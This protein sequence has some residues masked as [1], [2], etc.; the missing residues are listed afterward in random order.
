MILYHGSNVQ[1]PEPRLLK[2]QRDLDFG[3][4]FYASFPE[5][6]SYAKQ[7]ALKNAKDS[8]GNIDVKKN[9]VIIKFEID[10]N[11][12]RNVLEFKERNA[13]FIDFVFHTRLNYLKENLPYDVIIGYMADGTVDN[14]MMFY[15]KHKSKLAEKFVKWCYKLPFNLHRQIVIKSQSLCDEI[16]IKKVENLK[17][18]VIYESK[19]N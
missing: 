17:G 6:I 8:L 10:E 5:D 7:H 1:V 19:E 11:K 13:D 14:L 9:T 4:G 2:I 15:L 18:D 16:I 12:F 3:K